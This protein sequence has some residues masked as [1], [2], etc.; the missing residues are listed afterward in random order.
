MSTDSY[1]ADLHV[2]SSYKGQRLDQVLADLL[3]NVS[4]TEVKNWILSG[5]VAVDESIRR[6]SYRVTGNESVSVRAS[7]TNVMDWDSQ[8]DVEFQIVFEDEH[9]LVV[10]KPPGVVVH[11]GAGNP[12]GTLVNGLIAYRP[13]LAQLPRAGIV[14]RLDKDTSG[15]LMVAANRQS[16]ELLVDAI[17]NRAVNREYLC[18]VEG[19]MDSVHQTDLKIGRHPIHRTRYQVR[20][21]GRDATT[22]FRPL[23][24]FRQHTLVN[25]KLGTGRTHQIRVHAQAI[26]F[27]IVGDQTYG[28][29]GILPKTPSRELVEVVRNFPRQALHAFEIG[30][31]HPSSGKA[32]RFRSD[33]P[34][35]MQMLIDVLS[36]DRDSFLDS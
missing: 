28:A 10:D 21:D 32:M 5:Y 15:L 11:P 16:V 13:S 22:A 26:R 25:A 14:H 33:T 31:E 2:P 30:F 27:P 19:K 18:V 35:D 8:Q 29:R 1:T 12:D 4:R 7:R 23:E 9:V 36:D 6:P 20:E 24:S 34:E 17:T 3:D